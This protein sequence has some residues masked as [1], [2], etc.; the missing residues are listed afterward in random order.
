MHRVHLRIAGRPSRLQNSLRFL[1][2]WM[3]TG[4][5]YYT[6][7]GIWR[8]GNGG[9]ANIVMLPIGGLCG[10]L[11][12]SLHKIPRFYS[13]RVIT[14]ALLGTCIV[15]IIELLTGIV[16]NRWLG[17]QIWD[18]TGQPGN[19]M[20]Q[21]CLPYGVLWFAIM[22]FTIWLEDRLR[23]SLWREGS[24]DSLGDI[25]KKLWTGGRL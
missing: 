10:V 21:I 18:Y 3:I 23:W 13:M 8:I 2:L 5:L 11:V 12:G 25:Y 14:Q 15:L 4:M 17:L 16:L 7:E 19:I 24:P 20:G 1:I 22:P 6:V 9:W